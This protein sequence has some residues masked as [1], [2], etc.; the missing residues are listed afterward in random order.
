MKKLIN[1]FAFLQ[2]GNK[3]N[4]FAFL[5]LM[6]FCFF[7]DK[8]AIAQNTGSADMNSILNNWLLGGL[9][10][11]FF[12]IV[13]YVLRTAMVVL[14]ENGKTVEFSFPLFRNMADNNKTVTTII[15]IIVVCGVLWAV[16][17]GV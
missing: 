12:G 3:Q 11:V 13:I 10:L 4:R 1:Q 2:L 15:L 17:Y 14:Q 9:A 5:M 16:N 8:M 6:L 7:F